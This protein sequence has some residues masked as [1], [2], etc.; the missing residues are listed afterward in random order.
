MFQSPLRSYTTFLVVL[1]WMHVILFTVLGFVPWL[2]FGG[3]PILME[4]WWRQGALYASPAVGLLV[5]AL[6]GL[7]LFILS[8]VI[9][10]LMDQRDLLEEI[11]L[12]N[13]RLLQITESRHPSDRPSK[14]D[15]FDLT[16]L[17]DT[18]EPIP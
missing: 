4:S 9:R 10:V 1:G 6:S 17:K 16:D 12:T 11:L 15:P 13:R 14:K 5:G 8:G 7:G 3:Q 2:I 18:E